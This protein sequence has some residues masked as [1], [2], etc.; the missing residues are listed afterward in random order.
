MTAM[1]TN[2]ATFMCDGGVLVATIDMPGRTMNVFSADLMDSL[3]GLIDRAASTRGLAGVV[4]TSA[5]RGTFVVGADLI[6]V[7][8]FTAAAKSRDRPA[9]VEQCGRLG[10]IFR[11]LEESPVPFVAAINGLALGGGLEL[12]MACHGRAAGR[13]AGVRLGLPEVKL[14]LLPGAGGTQRLPR[15]I[16]LKAALPMLLRGND[17]SAGAAMDL[18][19]VNA[20]VDSDTLI[21]RAVKLV[22]EI[23]R[24][25][26]PWD[27]PDYVPDMDGIDLGA[28][29]AGNILAQR[30][31]LTVT[32]RRENPAH[33]AI[34]RCLIGGL[35]KPIVPACDWEMECFVDLIRDPAVGYMVRT[36]FLD[37]RR[38]ERL[39][40]AVRD[41]TVDRVAAD[42]V[43]K[44]VRNLLTA[45]KI[46]IVDGNDAPDLILLEGEPRVLRSSPKTVA[47]LSAGGMPSARDCAVGLFVG[48][49]SAHGRVLEIVI[50]K[51]D[52]EAE[53]LSLALARK[54]R[55]VPLVTRGTR[56]VLA[57][58][59][60]AKASGDGDPA[61]A[62]IVA[63]LKA[64]DDG[65]V[66]D[67][68]LLDM[69]AVTA[70]VFPAN[71]GGPL[72][73][74]RDR[75]GGGGRANSV[76]DRP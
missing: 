66:G 43:S 62:V 55:A 10:R 33:D 64:Q 6:M 31:G 36:L 76:N 46:S 3:D 50:E 20:V 67:A 41:V 32:E 44:N 54:L 59:V 42:G 5:K 18:G 51:D 70:G 9:L 60:A 1:D 11:R 7:H 40:N 30:A 52:A 4:I 74:A 53:H 8:G 71:A 24:P 48:P 58:L 19:L 23:R 45:A 27:Q 68:D 63:A 12:A 69:A 17:I 14:G 47:V 15:L 2:I 13:D 26:P 38:G 49:A 22:H 34:L 65:L 21:A 39:L 29:G 56:S 73:A 35:S 61:S 57:D 16:G 72:T 28:P 25:A 75:R 37:R